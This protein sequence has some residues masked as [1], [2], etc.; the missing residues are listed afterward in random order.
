M[1]EKK[2]V[3]DRSL[4]NVGNVLA[5][6]HLNVTVPDQSLATFFYV[7]GLGFTR[8][9]YMDFGP[10]NVWINVGNQQ[11]HLPTN[12]PQVLRGQIGVVVPDLDDL[13]NRL[14]QVSRRL[15]QTEFRFKVRKQ[16]IDVICPWGNQIRCHHPAAFGGL[17]LGIPY[18][19][20][21]VPAKSARGIQRF[22]SQVMN[23]PARVAGKA[24][25]AICEVM[26]GPKQ[27]LRFRETKADLPEY[28][29]HHIAIYISDFSG[30]HRYLK[31]NRLISEESDPHQY[32]FQH[33]VDPDTGDKL[34]E[35]EHEV[36][37]LFHP[38]YNR[39]L[40]NRNPAQ[41][42]FGYRQGQDA[43]NP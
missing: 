13:H 21:D 30:P 32:R 34:F 1:A 25:E 6:E 40:V 29:G 24:G 31:K 27:I 12:N 3:F 19:N 8:D 15:S 4:E 14:Q 18:I 10:F 26:V 5:M 11:F 16:W 23:T 41:S 28:D 35:I 20:F 38:M 37:S 43:M 39:H 2:V 33:L 7:N 9:P 22:Y 36:R 42:F 17:N